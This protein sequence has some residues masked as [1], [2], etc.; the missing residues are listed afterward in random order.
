MPET[1]A[2]DTWLAAVRQVVGVMRTSDVV[3]LELTNGAFSV[4]VQRQPGVAHNQAPVLP[5]TADGSEAQLHSVLAPFT[6]LFYRSPT[7]SAGVY[8]ESGDW[9]DAETVVGLLE[10]MKIF[11]EIK[12]D[13]AGR[14]VRFA[15][16]NG[17][18]VHTGDPLLLL[19]PGE[20]A[21]AEPQM[22]V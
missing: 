13:V 6:G 3:E 9:V 22:R 10:T 19:E 18:L 8:V 2:E 4:R 21:T 15:A 11:N 12:S 17:Q 20:R 14:I 16:E 5:S 1:V 7:P